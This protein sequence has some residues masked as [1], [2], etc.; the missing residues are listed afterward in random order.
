MRK[1]SR[2]TASW[3]GT[4]HLRV[5]VLLKSAAS[6]CSSAA[7]WVVI[8]AMTATE[9]LTVAPIAAA[10]AGEPCSCG[11]RSAA[12]PMLDPPPIPTCCGAQCWLG[13]YSTISCVAIW[14]TS[15]IELLP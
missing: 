2:P 14:Q 7:I 4:D 5:R 6:C 10:T 8:S 1:R 15:T 11:V 13:Q 9:A 3:Q 12:G